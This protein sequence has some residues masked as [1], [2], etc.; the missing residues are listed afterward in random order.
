MRLL[1]PLLQIAEVKF[2]DLSFTPINSGFPFLFGQQ[3]SGADLAEC[4]NPDLEAQ[5]DRHR[6]ATV[7]SSHSVDTGRDALS[8]L[9]MFYRRSSKLKDQLILNLVFRNTVK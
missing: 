4:S 9:L 7:K 2:G 3:L 8:V 5:Q 1:S 6:T